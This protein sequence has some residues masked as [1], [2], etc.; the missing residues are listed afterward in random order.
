MAH[1][2]I[3]WDQSSVRIWKTNRS[4]AH[5]LKEFFA[6]DVTSLLSQLN[7]QLPISKI[8]YLRFY[9][10]VPELDHHI[11]RVPKIAP[12][13]KKQLLQQREQKMYGDEARVLVSKEMDLNL[14][15]AQSFY[16]ISSLPENISIYITNWAKLNGIL[17]EGIYSLPQSIAYLCRVEE[18]NVE[19]FI[20]FQAIGNACYLIAR[21][22]AGEVLFFSRMDGPNPEAEKIETVARRLILFVEQEFSLTPA[23]QVSDL[24][25]LDEAVLIS[26][27]SRQKKQGQFSLV[28]PQE[29]RRQSLQRIRHRAF[30]FL[31]ISLIGVIYFTI[32]QVEKKKNLELELKEL[33]LAIQ[34]EQNEVDQLRS[35]LEVKS[36]YIDVIDF[37]EGRE[38]IEASSPIPSPLLVMLRALSNSLPNFVEIDSYEGEIDTSNI[39]ATFTMVG[40][41]LTA[42]LDLKNE[43]RKMY[44]R[45]KKRGWNIDEPQLY[46]EEKNRYSRIAEQR[47]DL[48]KF[49]LTFILSNK[50]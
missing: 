12:K 39:Q 40:R 44:D 34:L 43:V 9:V 8:T 42:D 26:S 35:D 1:I 7:T 2:S 18:K 36:T 28:R 4:G 48:R 29:K 37:C 21:D 5:L 45:L 17:L 20:Q 6:D 15:A 38:T 49:T 33:D 24:A 19:A 16:L 22:A 3:I 50:S 10:D 13:L 30:A 46:F 32:P 14:E 41:P 25:D 23:L 31:S 27:L 11:E 47:G